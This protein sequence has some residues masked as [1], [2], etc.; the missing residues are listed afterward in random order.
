[1]GVGGD[2]S[3]QQTGSGGAGRFEFLFVQSKFVKGHEDF[4]AESFFVSGKGMDA[5]CGF[6]GDHIDFIADIVPHSAVAACGKD[7]AVPV[8]CNAVVF[9][10]K[11]QNFFRRAAVLFAPVDKFFKG[12]DLLKR[13]HGDIVTDG[14][15]TYFNAFNFFNL[16]SGGIFLTECFHKKIV[17]S[18][19]DF[20][21]IEYPVTQIVILHQSRKF[22]SSFALPVVHAVFLIVICDVIYKRSFDKMCH[23]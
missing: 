19:A 4:S 8:S 15:R 18:I 1:M 11:Y 22:R 7:F 16:R 13:E 5:F 21:R 17:L 14:G 20:R 10:G 3:A 6:D 12:I 9:R 23:T 2:V